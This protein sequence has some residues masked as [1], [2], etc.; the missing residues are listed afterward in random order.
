MDTASWEETPIPLELEH[1]E[2]AEFISGIINKTNKNGIIGAYFSK[3]GLKLK[4]RVVTELKVGRND[5]CPCGSNK[6]YKK[7]CGK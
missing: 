1:P 6:K 5:S 7:C 3:D 2:I 4:K